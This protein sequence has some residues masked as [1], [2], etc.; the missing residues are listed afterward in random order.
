VIK[1]EKKLIT[2]C[3]LCIHNEYK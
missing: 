1:K 2:T 3:G